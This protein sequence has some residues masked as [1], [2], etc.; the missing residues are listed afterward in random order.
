MTPETKSWILCSGNGSGCCWHSHVCRLKRSQ[1]VNCHWPQC[2]CNRVDIPGSLWHF[3]L[4]LSRSD[5]TMCWLTILALWDQMCVL[6]VRLCVLSS[7]YW[8]AQWEY[9]CFFQLI[10]NY[11]VLFCGT[12]GESNE[13][14]EEKAS[15]ICLCDYRTQTL[16][17]CRNI[18]P[19]FSYSC[20]N[21]LSFDW[22]SHMDA[23]YRRRAPPEQWKLIIYLMQWKPVH[24]EADIGNNY[25]SEIIICLQFGFGFFFLSFL[26][27]CSVVHGAG[28][29]ITPPLH[30]GPKHWW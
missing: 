9:A 24:S 20:I 2:C 3:M 14:Q 11:P 25:N 7:V 6:C 4:F 22:I 19:A 30:C 12:R 29:E 1:Y 5:E 18:Q 27:H 13:T 15:A 26:K 8:L 28:M 23:H 10:L 21:Q 17:I 16:F